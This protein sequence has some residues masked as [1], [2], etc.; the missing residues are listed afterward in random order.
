MLNPCLP[1]R[2]VI[3]HA[4]S[5]PAARAR[6]TGNDNRRRYVGTRFFVGNAV[7]KLP[8]ASTGR[9]IDHLLHVGSAIAPFAWHHEV[10]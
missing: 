8:N 5:A 2:L 3:I 4:H 1:R 9:R 6:R 7:G 10:G